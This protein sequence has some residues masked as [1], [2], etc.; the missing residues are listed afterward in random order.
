[1]VSG[2]E[3]LQSEVLEGHQD[4]VLCPEVPEGDLPKEDGERKDLQMI[5]QEL[6]PI[7]E[8]PRRRIEE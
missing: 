1:M 5:G 7:Q 4:G 2:G 6:V 8:P 3:V